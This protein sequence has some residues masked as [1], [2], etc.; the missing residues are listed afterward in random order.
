MH[1][2]KYICGMFNKLHEKQLFPISVFV[3]VSKWKLR[4]V[5][6]AYG[7]TYM[8]C[9]ISTKDDRNFVEEHFKTAKPGPGQ[10]L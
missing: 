4:G 5:K 3:Q 9:W 8:A 7:K 1:V 10:K 2:Y 6:H